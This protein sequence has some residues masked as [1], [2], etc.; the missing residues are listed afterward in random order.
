MTAAA[1]PSPTTPLLAG[2]S[3][4]LPPS[5][6]LPERLAATHLALLGAVATGRGGVAGP[7]TG[8]AGLRRDGGDD[9]VHART[10]SVTHDYEGTTLEATVSCG[11]S[12]DDG[13]DEEMHAQAVSGLMAVHGRSYGRPTRIGLNVCSMAAGVLLVHAALATLI[14]ARRGRQMTGARTSAVRAALLF[15]SHH[16]AAATCGDPWAPPSPWTKPGPPVRSLD[17]V[18]F[19]LEALSPEAWTRFWVSL[20]AEREV[21]ESAWLAF[22]FRQNTAYCTLPDGLHAAASSATMTS[23]CQAATAAGVAICG[24]RGYADVVRDLRSQAS[25]RQLAWTEEKWALAPGITPWVVAPFPATARRPAPREPPR[26]DAP[27]NGIRVVES[28]TRI[29]G[30]LAGLLLRHLGADVVRVEPPGGDPARF[31]APRAGDVGAAFLAYNCGKRVVELDYATPA[32]RRELHDLIGTADV[33]LHNWRKGRASDLG[34][35]AS[36]VSAVNP[37]AVYAEAT[38]WGVAENVPTIAT[39]PLVQ[40]HAACGEGI[41]PPDAPAFPSRVT[42][43]DCMGGLLAAEAILAALY[44]RELTGSGAAVS[45]SLLSGGLTLEADVIQGLWASAEN[46]RLRGRPAWGGLDEPVE[47]AD[48]FVALDGSGRLGRKALL[49]AISRTGGTRTARTPDGIRRALRQRTTAVWCDLLRH[50]GVRV[51]PVRTTLADVSTSSLQRL[52]TQI[53]GAC[54]VPGSPL[55]LEP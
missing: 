48:G 55:V 30:P 43:A 44:H 16:I 39:D 42:L 13:C 41:R 53:D 21:A 27:L 6:G 20:G 8:I 26:P 24:L 15:L 12:S 35:T 52:L 29:Q 1:S 28:T 47:T 50:R 32:G 18:W 51:A 17:G 46:A 3:V 10:I 11:S 19:E 25:E 45:T 36:D 7:P 38:G 33:F 22:A 9:E 40:A 5:A 49:D 37:A 23:V 14:C 2:M 34:L 31:V 54:W 4:E